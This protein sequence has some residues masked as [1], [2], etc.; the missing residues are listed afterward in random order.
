MIDPKYA[1]AVVKSKDGKE[2]GRAAAPH[3]SDYIQTLASH[4]KEVKIDYVEDAAFCNAA[5]MMGR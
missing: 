1:V 3:A 4:Q 2:L 5:R